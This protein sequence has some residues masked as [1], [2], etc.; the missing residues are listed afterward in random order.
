MFG[1]YRPE[2]LSLIA[3]ASLPLAFAPLNLFVLAVAAPALLFVLWRETTPLRAAR[4]GFL[5]GL[6]MFGVGVSW[7]YVTMHIFGRMAPPLAV[8]ATA[9]FV[10][11]L[12]LF[13]AAV[14]Y[15]QARL[16]QLPQ[17]ARYLVVMPVLWVLL[18]WARSW[19]LTGFPWLNLGYSQMLTPLR[20]IAPWLGVYG[21]S[22][23]VAL[24]AGIFAWAWSTRERKTMISSAAALAILWLLPLLLAQIQWVRP[25]DGPLRIAMVQG[26][27]AIQDKWRP[28]FRDNILNMY[29]NMSQQVRDADAIIWPEGS[30]PTYLQYLDPVFIGV[31]RQ[32]AEK[33]GT[34]FMF[35]TIELD[36]ARN[37]VYYNSAVVLGKKPGIYRKVHLVPFGE[38]PPLDPLFR[39][40]MQSMQIP[41]ANFT[42]GP[43]G[44]QML[45]LA[46]QPIATSICYENVFGEELIHMLPRATLLVNISENAWYGNSLAA[47]Q[48]V[49]M[50]QMR[51]LEFGRPVVRA[52]NAG[53]SVAI[54]HLGHIQKTTRPF[55]TRVLMA[56]VQPMTGATPYVQAGNYPV[57]AWLLLSL[58]ALCFHYRQVLRPRPRS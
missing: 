46:G 35:G 10:S 14:G 44:Q 17:T 21:V 20:H 29:L 56:S 48:L 12:A 47:Y 45:S 8:I 41:M 36:S 51:S 55:E 39:W 16:G 13:P 31:L 58:F 6:G 32:E 34:D 26:N 23:L 57:L 33:Y 11:A 18:E 15:C 54:D 37:G 28:E 43:A 4:L 42:A 27:V 9:M 50:A 1:R 25:V 19:V 2:L 5:F 52:D 40:V 3:G 38:Y 24:S 30:I 49:Q 7:V 53:P 22:Y